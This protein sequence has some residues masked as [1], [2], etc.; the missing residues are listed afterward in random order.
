MVDQLFLDCL[1]VCPGENQ[2]R[3]HTVEITDF[4]QN[5]H[6]CGIW[7]VNDWGK[8]IDQNIFFPSSWGDHCKSGHLAPIHTYFISHLRFSISTKER[9]CKNE[10]H[11]NHVLQ[12]SVRY[13]FELGNSISVCGFNLKKVYILYCCEYPKLMANIWNVQNQIHNY[14]NTHSYSNQ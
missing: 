2:A 14:S 6:K 3:G 4:A 10:I 12:L 13:S 8:N 11:W 1:R 5:W 7:W 9:P